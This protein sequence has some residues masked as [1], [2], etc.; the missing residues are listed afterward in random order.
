MSFGICHS[1]RLPWFSPGFWASGFPVPRRVAQNPRFPRC[2]VALPYLSV[3]AVIEFRDPNSFEFVSTIASVTSF[4][5]SFSTYVTAHC[6]QQCPSCTPCDKCE[7]HQSHQILFLRGYDTFAH[8]RRAR[9][10]TI[11]G[12]PYLS[13]IVIVIESEVSL[14]F[15]V[16]LVR[17]STVS[18]TILSVNWTCSIC[19]V[20]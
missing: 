7:A 9:P 2:V 20:F 8:A 10:L 3:T 1:C 19:A 6:R 15:T 5:F 17:M 14:L 18:S 4:P 16:G 11:V 13:V 12:R